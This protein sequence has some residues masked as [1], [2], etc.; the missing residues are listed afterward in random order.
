MANSK[1]CIEPAPYSDS[2]VPH[3]LFGLIGPASLSAFQGRHFEP[4][5]SPYLCHNCYLPLPRNLMLPVIGDRRGLELA[6]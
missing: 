3:P 6:I 4:E 5:V 2:L 1:M